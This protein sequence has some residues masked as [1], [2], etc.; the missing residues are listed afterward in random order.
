V[1]WRIANPE[2]AQTQGQRLRYYRDTVHRMS[3][4]ELGTRI[5]IS[6]SQIS[7]YE[8]DEDSPTDRGAVRWL[9]TAGGGWG[10]R[11]HFRSNRSRYWVPTDA[12]ERRREAGLRRRDP[13]SAT[14]AEIAFVPFPERPLTR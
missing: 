4:E 3:Q 5:G 10:L 14:F 6:G 12:V 9:N 8:N 11:D 2:E 7:R 1:R 13:V